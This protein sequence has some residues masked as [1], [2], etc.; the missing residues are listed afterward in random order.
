MDLLFWQQGELVS[1]WDVIAAYFVGQDALLGTMAYAANRTAVTLQIV[2]LAGLSDALGNSVILLANKIRPFRFLFALL[3]NVLLYLF[4]YLAW[5][6]SLMLIASQIF[7][8]DVDFSFFASVVALSYIPIL[9]SV[10]TFLPYFGYPIN[11]LLYGISTIYLIRILVAATSLT[12]LNAFGCAILGFIFLSV[13]RATVGR[14]FVHLGQWVVT[15]A[16]GRKLEEN[17]EAALGLKE[18]TPS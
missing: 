9:F 12:T 3:A 10:F 16:A 7:G 11:L 13:M 14:P 18:T 17:I 5:A 8:L 2:F 1:L 6:V 4:G 15:T